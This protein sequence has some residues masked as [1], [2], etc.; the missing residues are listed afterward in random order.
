MR[1]FVLGACLAIASCSVFETPEVAALRQANS[2]DSGVDDDGGV[3]CTGG[4]SCGVGMECVGGACV[5]ATSN[6]GGTGPSCSTLSGG[7]EC[8]GSPG[9]QLGWSVSMCNAQ[10]FVAGAPGT[11]TLLRY[12]T[13][14]ATWLAVANATEHAGEAVLCRPNLGTMVAGPTGVFELDTTG[15]LAQK[16]SYASF[17]LASFNDLILQKQVPLATADLSAGG[18]GVLQLTANGFAEAAYGNEPWGASLATS[19]DGLPPIIAV[20]APG[21]TGGGAVTLKRSG[22]TGTGFDV[23]NTTSDLGASPHAGVAIAIGNVW[24]DRTASLAPANEVLV[25]TS[26]ELRIYRGDFSNMV[27][28]Y[29]FPN[30]IGSSAGAPVSVVVDDSPLFTSAEIHV[31]Y[32][33][34]PAANTVLRCLG[35][36]CSTW[37]VGPLPASD[38]GASLAQSGAA[39]VV[40]APSASA[41]RGAV[42][43]LSREPPTFSGELQECTDTMPCCTSASLLGTCVGGVFCQTTSTQPAMECVADAGAPDAGEVDAGEIDAGV[44][45][46]AGTKHDAGTP[47]AGEVDAG[48]DGGTLDDMP[49]AEF[50][51]RGCSTVPG[52][53]VGLMAWALRRRRGSRS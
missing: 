22:S 19:P 16:W 18:R 3:L 34:L 8:L 47:D 31:F 36:R 46:D 45:E 37:K 29:T 28:S 12:G 14:G 1:F 33:G 15:N 5:P 27:G 40:G 25:A 17:A 23:A 43:L 38:F 9:M 50:A 10:T 53:W 11:S 48:V 44:E 51:A 13:G 21:S 41:G 6:D 49:P 35:T 4:S 42:Y 39:V 26:T 7:L 20:G 30:G 2:G 52:V 24:P 32:V